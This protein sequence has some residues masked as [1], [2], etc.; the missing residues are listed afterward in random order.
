MGENGMAGAFRKKQYWI[1]KSIALGYNHPPDDA[2]SYVVNT[3]V[4]DTQQ[5]SMRQFFI[6]KGEAG[7]DWKD[8]MRNYGV[9]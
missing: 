8:A 5:G 2:K 9:N 3:A 1:D 7:G 4:E 6:D